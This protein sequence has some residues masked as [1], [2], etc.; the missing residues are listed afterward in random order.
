MLKLIKAGF[1]RIRLFGFFR[2]AALALLA[3]IAVVAMFA[4]QSPPY[5]TLRSIYNS[6]PQEEN[7]EDDAEYWIS[8][9]RSGGGLFLHVRHTARLDSIDIGGFDYWELASP[10]DFETIQDYVCLTEEGKTQAALLGLALE[11][12]KIPLF[13]VSS[14]SCR[15]KET[16]EISALR[17]D[18]VDISAMYHSAIPEQ[19]KPAF[20]EDRL[21]FFENHE[22]HGGR[23]TVIFGHERL[24]F[25]DAEWV[26]RED[27]EINRQQGGI[28]IMS[29]NPVSKEATVHYTFERIG[30]LVMAVF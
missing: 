21:D 15:A 2:P 10:G 29:W 5:S 3:Y 19:Q 6:V 23:T 7:T 27:G 28:S 20:I 9:L 13:V 1:G 11:Q 26:V 18:L 4:T 22:F 24:P 12:L 17:I 8:Q 25:S 14:P 30:D 16:A